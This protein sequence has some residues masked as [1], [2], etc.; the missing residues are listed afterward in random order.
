MESIYLTY[1]VLKAFLKKHNIHVESLFINPI[2]RIRKA[3]E[4]WKLK[5]SPIFW[6]DVPDLVNATGHK[7]NAKVAE[8]LVGERLPEIKNVYDDTIVYGVKLHFCCISK[9]A[10]NYAVEQYAQSYIT[11]FPL[12][13]DWGG[14]NTMEQDTQSQYVSN[15][16]NA[17]YSRPLRI[18]QFEGSKA[19]A[20]K[21]HPTDIDIVS[22][23][24]FI[25][26]EIAGFRC[27]ESAI[28][29]PK[30]QEYRAKIKEQT[31]QYRQVYRNLI[32][33]RKSIRKADSG[34][35]LTDDRWDAVKA[36]GIKKADI[37]L[38]ST[39]CKQ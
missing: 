15:D 28:N 4:K 21:E 13:R 35:R 24:S 27:W 7:F 38:A 34:I 5:W 33:L 37:Y 36:T 17:A 23:N 10:I 6:K 20:I 12:Y 29:D 11:R 18:H 22:Y 19:R 9:D 32:D 1:P 3:D 39:N 2:E 14:Y 8:I 16:R 25:K 26:T 30:V 31:Q